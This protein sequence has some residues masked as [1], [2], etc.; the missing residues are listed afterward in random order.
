M[1]AVSGG[2]FGGGVVGGIGGESMEFSATSGSVWH[3]MELYV[4]LLV[5]ESLAG[6]PREFTTDSAYV[7]V[8]GAADYSGEFLDD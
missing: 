4:C 6:T 3:F 7:A 2:V 1:A 5:C 8:D